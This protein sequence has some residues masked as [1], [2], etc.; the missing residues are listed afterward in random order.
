[1][2]EPRLHYILR[3]SEDGWQWGKES[4]EA[5]REYGV[6]PCDPEAGTA[7]ISSRLVVIDGSDD[8]LTQLIQVPLNSPPAPQGN[9]YLLVFPDSEDCGC[10]LHC[11]TDEISRLP[12]AQSA[13]VVL[14]EF[15]G[16]AV[17]GGRELTGDSL[18]DD[19]GFLNQLSDYL[20]TDA[21]VYVHAYNAENASHLHASSAAAVSMEPDV[22]VVPPVLMALEQEVLHFVENNQGV[23]ITESAL[24]LSPMSGFLSSATIR[25]SEG[26]VRGADELV[27]MTSANANTGEDV[28]SSFFDNESGC[29]LLFGKAESSVYTAALQ[30]VYFSSTAAESSGSGREIEVVITEDGAVSNAMRRSVAIHESS[31][32]I[33]ITESQGYGEPDA[34]SDSLMAID[35]IEEIPSAKSAETVFTIIEPAPGYDVLRLGMPVFCFTRNDVQRGYIKLIHEGQHVSPAS[36]YLEVDSGCGEIFGVVVAVGQCEY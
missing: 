9:T 5:A 29:L 14:R 35:E 11:L 19:A 3:R 28:I 36:I 26:F 4:S 6:D 15:D 20:E 34:F 23:P 7:S 18:P 8:T 27:Y 13:H 21:V 25:L 17:L 10:S 31:S 1:M 16:K 33:A 12:K 32:S 24:T 2:L 22:L 30:R